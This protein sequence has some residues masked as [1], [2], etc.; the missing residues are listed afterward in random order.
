MTSLSSFHLSQFC[1]KLKSVMFSRA[2]VTHSHSA[3]LR[4]SLGCKV[5]FFCANIYFSYIHTYILASEVVLSTH[6]RP[7]H[8]PLQANSASYPQRDKKWAYGLLWLISW[9]AAVRYVLYYVHRHVL[10]CGIVW[11]RCCRITNCG[12]ISWCQW[13]FSA[14][15]S[16]LL[17][18]G[19]TLRRDRLL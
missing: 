4:D 12:A 13:A 16:L 10:Q 11:A 19:R 17:D 7:A 1:A 9:L 8:T 15:S 6:T 5:V 2:H 3:G 18:R 14:L